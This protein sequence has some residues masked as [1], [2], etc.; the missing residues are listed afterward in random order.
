MNGLRDALSAGAPLYTLTKAI[1]AVEDPRKDCACTFVS[2]GK[3]SSDPPPTC[4]PEHASA[5]DPI[6]YPHPS[7]YP[8]SPPGY[9]GTAKKAIEVGAVVLDIERA[10]VPH[11]RWIDLGESG[12]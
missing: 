2:H 12:R 7:P 8:L 9:P 4:R 3:L 10:A 11:V 5:E 1:A 6:P